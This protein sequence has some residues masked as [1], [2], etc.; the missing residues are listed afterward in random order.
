MAQGAQAISRLLSMKEGEGAPKL[1]RLVVSVCGLK[2]AG[3]K[4][5]AG[6]LRGNDTLT[7]LDISGNNATDASM[8]LLGEAIVH[9]RTLETLNLGLNCIGRRGLHDL[10]D[11]ATSRQSR[12]TSDSAEVA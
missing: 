6:A 8:H 10:L 2:D 3:V 11:S 12:I 9:N 7:E 5:F 4:A 1:R